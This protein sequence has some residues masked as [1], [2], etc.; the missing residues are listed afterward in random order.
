MTSDVTV[1]E[2]TATRTV[3]VTAP[4]TQR[5]IQIVDGPRTVTV[6]S[7]G[8][9]RT[10]LATTSPRIALSVATTGLQGA[11]GPPGP[12]GPEGP[13]G[14]P[15]PVGPVGTVSEQRF[16]FAA[17]STQWDA[18]HAFPIPNPDV[19]TLD[20]AGVPIVGDVTYPTPSTVRVAWFRPTAGAI[21]VTP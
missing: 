11:T 18:V 16:D 3:T 17:P 13:Q 21:V 19:K 20:P 9:Q 1:V 10:I 12:T 7:P 15:G 14:P 5:T 4:G 8:A 2:V 6:T